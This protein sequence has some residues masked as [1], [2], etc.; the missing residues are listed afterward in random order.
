[1][2]ATTPK[3]VA[4][5]EV[6]HAFG[7]AALQHPAAA[8]AELRAHA[9]VGHAAGIGID[10]GHE[11]RGRVELHDHAP[12]A[13]EPALEGHEALRARA[14]VLRVRRARAGWTPWCR[15]PRRRRC[16]SRAAARRRPAA[17]PPFPLPRTGRWPWA[18]SAA[19]PAPPASPSRF[20][21]PRAPDAPRARGCRGPYPAGPPHRTDCRLRSRTSTRNWSLGK[22]ERP[23]S[24]RPS[25]SCQVSMT[26]SMRPPPR[27][28]TDARTPRVRPRP[29]PRRTVSAPLRCSP[30]T[31]KRRSALRRPD[32][33]LDAE[34]APPVAV[35]ARFDAP[36]RERIGA[37]GGQG[38]EG[39]GEKPLVARRERAAS[40]GG[41]S[42]PR[43]S[44]GR[45]RAPP[46]P[47]P[48]AR[49]R[50]STTSIIAAPAAQRPRVSG[51]PGRSSV[52]RPSSSTTRPLTTTYST[53]SE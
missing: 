1:M 53:P 52:M 38:Q 24:G 49:A 46:S 35:Q 31:R 51:R 34:V 13:R 2:A 11:P 50:S 4:T 22:S 12:P 32:V 19:R 23:P 40:H 41:R 5:D 37:G 10:V 29:K 20:R 33:A 14:P 39:L 6:V 47:S 48:A 16:E 7:D 17:R 21:D 25:A 28:R 18:G 30:S 42:G 27:H 44:R 45:R 15:G 26:P 8:E 36:S 3:S 9:Q 43:R